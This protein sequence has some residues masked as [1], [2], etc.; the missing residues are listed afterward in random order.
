M[1]YGIEIKDIISSRDHLN[2]VFE[3]EGLAGNPPTVY[4]EGNLFSFEIEGEISSE[5]CHFLKALGYEV[6]IER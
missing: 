2:I 1:K 6:S 4:K 5:T 3:M